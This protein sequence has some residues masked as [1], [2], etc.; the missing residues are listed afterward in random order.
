MARRT[1]EPRGHR[2]TA[3]LYIY[4]ASRPRGAR[5]SRTTAVAVGIARQTWFA[6]RASGTAR[7]VAVDAP[8]HHR[9]RVLRH[10]RSAGIPVSDDRE[11]RVPRSLCAHV[12]PHGHVAHC[13]ADA[14]PAVLGVVQ[15]STSIRASDTV[16]AVLPGHI[17]TSSTRR[18]TSARLIHRQ[19][20]ARDNQPHTSSARNRA[21]ARPC[22]RCLRGARMTS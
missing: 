19:A 1:H 22:Y 3:G 17:D 16:I 15:P 9:T 20:P 21:T 18:M 11:S 10:A 7:P 4:R 13:R 8:G 14:T 12:T 5:P 6:P 2:H